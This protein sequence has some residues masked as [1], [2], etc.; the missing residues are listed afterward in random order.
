MS[1]NTFG[2]EHTHFKEPIRRQLVLQKNRRQ[3]LFGKGKKKNREKSFETFFRMDYFTEGFPTN[4]GV[5]PKMGKLMK[6]RIQID[7]C[8]HEGSFSEKLC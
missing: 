6:L 7:F 3:C 1:S 2:A 4:I 8:S 5:K